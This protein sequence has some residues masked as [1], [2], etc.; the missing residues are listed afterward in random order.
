MVLSLSKPLRRRVGSR[1]YRSFAHGSASEL[2]RLR[3][4][5]RCWSYEQ[6]VVHPIADVG[7]TRLLR[8][9]RSPLKQA[10]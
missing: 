7:G 6:G 1:N 8:P 9:E 4:P 5:F 10:I 3:A 2:N